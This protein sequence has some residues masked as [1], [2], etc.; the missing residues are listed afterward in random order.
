[1]AWRESL[2]MGLC[3]CFSE[4]D[5]EVNK[6]HPTQ[7]GG[8]W[9]QLQWLRMPS[10]MLLNTEP[11]VSALFWAP[12]LCYSEQIMCCLGE[13][14][15]SGASTAILLTPSNIFVAWYSTNTVP[16]PSCPAACVFVSTCYFFYF[17]YLLSY[18]VFT[19]TF[20]VITFSTFPHPKWP[21]GELIWLKISLRATNIANYL[22]I[23]YYVHRLTCWTHQ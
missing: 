13:C 17:L 10:W 21:Q 20:F 15:H 23:C 9:P 5:I 14:G 2:Q 4:G 7:S 12:W 19:V 11:L 18:L 3:C 6:E 1:M 16:D 22:Y 8:I